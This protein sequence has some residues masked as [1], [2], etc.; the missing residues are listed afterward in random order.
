MNFLT[1]TVPAFFAQHGAGI[2]MGI[3][4]SHPALLATWAVQGIAAVPG[5]AAL[6]DAH[7]SQVD[8]FVAA[9]AKAA[10]DA[11]DKRAAA[12]AAK[13]LQDAADK[14]KA[15]SAAAALPGP[16]VTPPQGQ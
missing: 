8:A 14:A 10:Q 2:L 1:D 5:G 12:D 16:V 9:F 6:L 15:V 7:T 3:A 11:V 13:A 4:I